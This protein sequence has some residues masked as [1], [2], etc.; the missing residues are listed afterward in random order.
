MNKQ[1]KNLIVLGCL[2]V[3]WAVSWHYNRLPDQPVAAAKAKAVKTAAQETMLTMRFHRIR[4]E[5]DGLYHYRLKPVAFETEGN[6]FRLPSFMVS[7]DTKTAATEAPAASGA[8]A[9]VIEVAP[10]VNEPSE[11]GESLLKHAVEATRIGGVVTM[12]DTSELN[13]N[14]ELHKEGEVFTARVK[15]RLVLVKIKRLTTTFAIMTL[16]DPEAGNAEVRVR[17]N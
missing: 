17:L 15:A 6:P 13:V 12:N 7:D 1:T 8:K 10:I 3:A 14:G 2:V 11:S 16:D 5:M 4:A 9:P